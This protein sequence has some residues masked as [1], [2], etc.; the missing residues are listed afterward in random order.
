MQKPCLSIKKTYLLLLQYDQLL[1]EVLDFLGDLLLFLRHFDELCLE[2]QPALL[3]LLDLLSLGVDRFL[4]RVDL[5][6]PE[7][8]IREGDTEI[9]R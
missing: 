1:A 6:Q 7:S 4:Q 5:Q 9:R 2:A 3:R 8:E